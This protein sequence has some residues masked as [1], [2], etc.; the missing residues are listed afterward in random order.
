MASEVAVWEIIQLDLQPLSNFGV[1]RFL[2][3]LKEVALLALVAQLLSP[4]AARRS[5]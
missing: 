5:S 3:Q 4:A 1:T 2:G